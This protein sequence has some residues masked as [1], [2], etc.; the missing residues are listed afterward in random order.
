MPAAYPE[1]HLGAQPGSSTPSDSASSGEDYERQHRGSGWCA[2]EVRQA[3]NPQD[4]EEEGEG[5]GAAMAGS[6]GMAGSSM[7]A[8]ELF[9]LVDIVSRNFMGA[10]SPHAPD[11]SEEGEDGGAMVPCSLHEDEDSGA[12]AMEPG[13]SEEGEESGAMDGDT[14]GSEAEE[15]DGPAQTPKAEAEAQAE[16][17]DEGLLGED[18]SGAAAAVEVRLFAPPTLFARST[19]VG[20][21][22]SSPQKEA[23]P[24]ATAASAHAH[25]S[26]QPH[27]AGM[28]ADAGAAVP[29]AP[30]LGGGQVPGGRHSPGG[31]PGGGR[32][33]HAHE[34]SP[35]VESVSLSGLVA[36]ALGQPHDSLED[37][38]PAGHKLAAPAPAAGGLPRYRAKQPLASSAPLLH[39][40]QLPSQ[41]LQHPHPTSELPPSPFAMSMPMLGSGKAKGAS[42]MHSIAHRMAE[43]GALG[44]TL[45]KRAGGGK[46]MGPAW[47]SQRGAASSSTGA[48]GTAGAHDPLD[49]FLQDRPII[50]PRCVEAKRDHRL[51]P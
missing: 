32:D 14:T 8:A 47:P 23:P 49:D 1:V 36:L 5:E 43:T 24:G 7:P 50:A 26:A 41:Q 18:P 27:A 34:D 15:R 45:G 3:M 17:I 16:D 21:S 29:P 46:H 20:R 48:L 39:E 40:P 35:A 51:L 4:E 37:R 19:S 38:L 28:H 9:S 12:G 25:L 42:G 22:I 10:A 31:S 44:Q 2:A 13:S 30:F 6:Q 11:S 33:V